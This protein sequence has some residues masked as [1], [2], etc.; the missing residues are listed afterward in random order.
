MI[1]YNSSTKYF[2]PS[3]LKID[4]PLTMSK[5]SAFTQ[6]NS[7]RVVLEIFSS[8]F[9]FC[10]I[11]GCYYWKVY[12][13]GIWLPDFSKLAI[14][15]KMTMIS[16]LAYMTSS[17]IFFGLFFGLLSSLVT[18]QSF[19]SIS[20]LGLQLWQFYFIRDWPEMWKSEI[21]PSKH[22]PISEDWGN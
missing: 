2:V 11:K 18:G 16:Q 9:S 13:S 6:S 19:M 12:T 4:N 17:S 10:K 5:T 15:W 8:V 7:V 22:C 3:L 21:P 20:S 14:N 1:E